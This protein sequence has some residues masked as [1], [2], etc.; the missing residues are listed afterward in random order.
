LPDSG[1]GLDRHIRRDESCQRYAFEMS[2]M[3]ELEKILGRRDIDGVE[4]LIEQ[5]QRCILQQ[6]AWAERANASERPRDLALEKQSPSA[7]RS[8]ECCKS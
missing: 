6:Q 3:D 4:G 1:R 2:L 5:N 7:E 8:L